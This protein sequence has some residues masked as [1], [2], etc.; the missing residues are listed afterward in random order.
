ML[1]INEVLANTILFALCLVTKLYPTLCNLK[2]C[3][4]ASFLCQWDFPGKDIGVGCQFVSREFSQP[5][6]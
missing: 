4:P 2:D 6:D 5:G 1:G 3:K